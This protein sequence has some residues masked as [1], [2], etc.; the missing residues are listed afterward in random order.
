MATKV[1]CSE[2]EHYKHAGLV[3]HEDCC[4]ASENMGNWFSRVSTVEKP[5]N[6]NAFNYCEWYKAK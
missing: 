6:I 2:C 5:W 1:Y 3:S 4:T